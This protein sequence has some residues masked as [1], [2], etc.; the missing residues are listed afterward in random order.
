MDPGVVLGWQAWVTLGVIVMMVVALARDMARPD[1][2][3]LG[4]LAILLV[5][6]IVTPMQAFAG[7]SNSAVLS[8]GA[9]FVVAQ[10]L[11]R[12]GALG[13]L[14]GL[15]FSESARP[16]RHLPRL[17]LPTSFMSA[18]L[19][20]T[21]IVAMI[22]PRVQRWAQRKNVATSKVMI[23]L[24]Y[25]AI[26]GGMTTLIGTS[27]NIVV[28]GLMEAAG[29]EPMG[30]FEIAWIGVPAALLITVYFAVVGH[31]FLPDRISGAVAADDG[32]KDCFFEV[33]VSEDATIAGKTVE[34]A[35]LRNLVDAF[36]VHVRRGQRFIPVRPQ[37]AVEAGDILSFTGKAEMIDR[38]LDRPGLERA[39]PAPGT[40]PG[41]ALPIFEAVVS[42]T[43]SLVGSTLRDASFRERYRGVVLAIQRKNEQLFGSLGRIRIRPGDL[44][45]IEAEPDFAR[46]WNSSRTDFYLVAPRAQDRSLP[47]NRRAPISLGI[48]AGMI[49]L[50]AANILPIVTASFAAAIGMIATRCINFEEARAGVDVSV[51]LIIAAA[52]GIGQ[53]VEVTGLAKVSADFLVESTA[54]LGPVALLVS[55]Y[56]ATN[57]LTEL[58]TH[59]AA[60]VLMFP[61][62]VAAAADLGFDPRPFAFV[63]AIG[64]AASFVTPI[65]YQTNLMVMS[66]GG[67]RYRDYVRNGL[68]VA[69]LV[70]A[71][72]VSVAV[73]VWL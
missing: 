19:N 64:A 11:Q 57:V 17:M 56:L 28:S 30:M 9:L 54:A 34:E 70:M 37:M 27:T 51:L 73:T 71:V 22:M 35:E 32:L 16:L 61:V 63:V 38:L 14:D 48:L 1:L 6:G 8:V 10:G 18:F 24:S 43:S 36:L 42:D 72:A 12:T 44:L 31:R 7:F 55:I 67:Y 21:P 68:P 2:I 23:P 5:V 60:A 40:G 39:L 66:A 59:K 52:L 26:L 49:A 15:L 33:R 69:L 29:L 50:V 53:A 25:A 47:G 65:G 3:L 41:G 62:A 13:F 4:S 58:I 46:R 45:L 20:N